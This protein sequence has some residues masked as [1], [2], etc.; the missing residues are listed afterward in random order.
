VKDNKTMLYKFPMPSKHNGVG[1]YVLPNQQL[2]IE[3]GR[4]RDGT[5]A[6][7]AELATGRAV[8]ISRPGI[9]D[10]MPKAGKPPIG[11][12]KVKADTM[13]YDDDA[14]KVISTLMDYLEDKLTPEQLQGVR[15]IL[16]SGEGPDL[17]A[18]EPT[19]ATD[20]RRATRLAADAARRRPMSDRN[21]EAY[22]QL[23]P[24]A[25]RLG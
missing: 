13:E 25:G 8:T 20:R 23:F 17:D 4:P 16:G 24:N 6:Y 21:E 2:G 12:N 1:L 22:L 7:D 19:Q 11:S 9:D 15:T 18:G 3:V 10:E 14:T 5:M